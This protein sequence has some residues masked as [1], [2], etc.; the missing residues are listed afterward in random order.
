MS[1][2]LLSLRLLGGFV[3]ERD[4]AAVEPGYV[5][6]RAL[7]AFLASAPGRAHGRAALAAMFWPDLERGAALANLRLVL[8]E[9]RR[10]LAPRAGTAP[11]LRIDRGSVTLDPNDELC[12]DIA[13]FGESTPHCPAQPSPAECG[14]CLERMESRQALYHGPFL[15]DGG[16]PDCP[17]FE[18]WVDR[19][20]ETLHL[21]A[22]GWLLRLADCHE[23]RGDYDKA[24]EFSRRL[25]DLEP[26]NED[27]LRR[28]M[29]LLALSGRR[30]D[31]LAQYDA[32][33]RALQRG[34]G[35]TPGDETRAL[36]ERV[37]Q[38]AFDPPPAT[39]AA[40]ATWE[41]RP[42]IVLRCEL[43]PAEATFPADPELRAELLAAPRAEVAATLT[44]A[45]ARLLLLDGGSLQA[46]FGHPRADPDMPLH[47][48]RAAREL[49]ARV[50]PGVAAR[51]GIAAGRAL[52]G[53]EPP[54]VDAGG[55]VAAA[56]RAL[57]A[58][59]TPGRAAF[60]PAMAALAQPG[61]A[62]ALAFDTQAGLDALG[63]TACLAAQIDALLGAEGDPAWLAQLLPGA[64]AA[65]LAA[66]LRAAALALLPRAERA[67]LQRRIAAG[68]GA[69]RPPVAAETRAAHWAAAGATAEAAA[70]YLEAGRHAAQLDDSHAAIAHFSAGLEQAQGLPEDDGRVRLELDLH[71]GLGAAA[72]AAEGYASA[73]GAAAYGA[74]R[75]L[76]ERHAGQ[77]DLFPAVWGIWASASST[78]GFA[79][80]RALAEQ[81]RHMADASGDP[82]HDQQANFALGNI[83]F[84]QGEF[85]AARQR[86]DAVLAAYRPE[87]HARHVALFGED[88]GVTAGAYLSW[89][90]WFLGQPDDARRASAASLAL[91]RRLKQPMSQAY[92]LIFAA[93]LHCRLGEADAV[94]PLAREALDLA[95]RH[96]FTLWRIGAGFTRGWAQVQLGGP[97]AAD[98]AEAMGQCIETMR[99]AMGG[100]TLTIQ[101]PYIDALLALG[102]AAEARH[103]CIEARAL[104]AALGDHHLDAELDRL[105]GEA[106]LGRGD[107]EAAAGCFRSALATARRQGARALELRAAA[108]RLRADPADAAARADLA[109]VLASLLQ[110]HDTLDQRDALRLLDTAE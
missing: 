67:A 73:L 90:L 108:S 63:P 98:G 110:G 17:E 24:L 88:A 9:L 61:D 57:C 35:G 97:A 8:H 99:V 22:L 94:L 71:L 21:R 43:Q 95:G 55:A 109:A 102:R 85:A 60:S 103:R 92:A 27:G 68:L 74:A 19:R 51:I 76:C 96:G 72:C 107:V 33:C 58:Q 86:L 106:L 41:I 11:A 29:R 37:R 10:L 83:H 2:P 50:W 34:V 36:A 69:M 104:G 59:A 12:I 44:A 32:G 84:W 75:A 53:G 15:G 38:G 30:E 93:L 25:L 31:A 42:L 100:V 4:G 6:G 46:S 28:T 48:A 105:E 40:A 101:V 20:R 1:Q 64:A 81:L 66:D 62:L 70:A 79:H 78:G 18:D 16:L 5:K 52:C 14:P 56:A 80:A 45:G 89:V 49:A 77:L 7:L 39:L 23:R 82:L 54:L 65:P 13:S 26:W 87:H 47:A 91:A 3:L